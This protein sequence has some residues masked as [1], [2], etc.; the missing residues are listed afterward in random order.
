MKNYIPT[1]IQEHLG[2]GGIV[3]CRYKHGETNISKF[4]NSERCID[5]LIDEFNQN[6]S[7]LNMQFYRVFQ[8]GP[9]E[10]MS[11]SLTRY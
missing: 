6:N 9:E 11:Y 5:D 4:T 10:T 2:I 7:I 3:M 1:I 8:P